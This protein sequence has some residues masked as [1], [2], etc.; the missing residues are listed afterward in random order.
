MIFTCGYYLTANIANFRHLCTCPRK[1]FDKKKH[2]HEDFLSLL[3]GAYV[4]PA[5]LLPHSNFND[6]ND[7]ESH[8]ST[9]KP[10]SI[11]L[12]K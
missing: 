11:S 4:S 1:V 12:S 8:S 2:Q 9:T 6:N 5:R 7:N 3:A 10:L